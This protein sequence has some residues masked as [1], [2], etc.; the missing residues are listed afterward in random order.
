MSAAEHLLAV[1]RLIY[2][3][4]FLP[5]WGW[6]DDHAMVDRSPAYKPAMQQV[7]AEFAELVHVLASMNVLAGKALQLGMGEAQASHSV[8]LELF[9]EV[10][11]IDF[12]KMVRS[13][14]LVDMVQSGANTHDQAAAEFAEAGAPYDFL[15]VDA[16]HSEDDVAA[17]HATY[18]PMVRP[19]GVIAFHDACKRAAFPEITV[20][21]YLEGRQG[22]NM[23]PGEVGI[24]WMIA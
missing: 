2:S 21:Q 4:R 20:W 5:Y 7:K 17:D 24:A 8:L 11:T 22:V 18:G 10:T 14:A 19:G 1:N 12:A 16:G 9:R 13:D 15:F 23:I 3:D 6:H